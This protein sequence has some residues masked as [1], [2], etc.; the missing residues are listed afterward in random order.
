MF[1]R[2]FEDYP[3]FDYECPV[4]GSDEI[5]EIDCHQGDQNEYLTDIDEADRVLVRRYTCWQCDASF[6][7]GE[8]NGEER[9]LDD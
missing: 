4:C 7:T 5:Q 1:E 9:H 6:K 8:I 3:E 2:L